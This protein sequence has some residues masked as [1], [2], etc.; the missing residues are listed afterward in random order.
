V[1]KGEIHLPILLDYFHQPQYSHAANLITSSSYPSGGGTLDFTLLIILTSRWPRSNGSIPGSGKNSILHS[2][3]TDSTAHPVSYSMA[4]MG[5]FP[6]KKW[7]G[8]KAN[9][10]L[11]PEH[12]SLM[13]SVMLSI[14]RMSSTYRD[15]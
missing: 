13:H 9:H 14:P 11:P 2:I 5:S 10:L 1:L 4:T 3:K 12:R 7:S 8:R 6:G 15:D